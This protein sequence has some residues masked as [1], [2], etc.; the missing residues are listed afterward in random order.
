VDGFKSAGPFGKKLRR[1]I[2]L[3]RSHYTKGRWLLLL[4]VLLSGIG[5]ALGVGFAYVA[6]QTDNTVS[7]YTINAG[8]GALT[9]VAGS[10][11]ATG[12]GPFSVTVAPS[13]AFAYVANSGSNNVSAYTIN[14]ATG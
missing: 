4:I 2:M 9:P 7:A 5:Q 11:F 13:G 10:P 6:N 8:T 12:T 14:A 3:D 1:R